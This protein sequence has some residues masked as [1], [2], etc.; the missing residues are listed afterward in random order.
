MKEIFPGVF[1]DGRRIFTINA[2]P[3]KSVYGEKLIRQGNIEF[4]EWDPFRS[5]LCGALRKGLK[6]FPFS[7]TS[8]VLYL[9]ASTGTTVSH[10]SDIAEE[11]EIYAVEMAPVMGERLMEV[12]ERRQ[13]IVPII[14][15]ARKP[16]EYAEIPE[17]DVLYQD[18][19]QPDQD[20]ILAINARQ[21]LK[22]GGIAML[23]V[24]SQSIDVTMDPKKVFAMVEKNLSSDF[25]IIEKFYLE[26]YDKEHE[27]LVLRLK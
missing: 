26:P 1:A 3:G 17:V 22:K 9:G 18:V 4:R 10:L 24:K 25:E 6:T 11:G 27:F 16:D 12:A 21:F 13:N 8:K 14:A 20:R 19:A 5:K 2:V 23:C 15:D 7:R